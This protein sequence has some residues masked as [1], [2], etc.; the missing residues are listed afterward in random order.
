[1]LAKMAKTIVV[2]VGGPTSSGKTTIAKHLLALIPP[3]IGVILHQDD[4]ALPEESLPFNETLQ[5][6]DWDN[7]IGT[8]DYKRM[9]EV[10]QHAKAFG[11]LPD[12]HSSHDHLN[13]QPER[14]LDTP[15][16]NECK[17]RLADA[18]R[19]HPEIQHI[20]FA[21]GFLLYYDAQVRKQMDIRLFL[22]CDRATLESRRNERG[23]YA[24]AENTVWQDP[25][26]YFEHVIWPGYVQA[27]K[28]MFVNEDIEHGSLVDVKEDQPTDGAPVKNLLLIEG[29]GTH[30]NDVVK[31]SVNEIVRFLDA[32]P[33]A[34]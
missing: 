33:S 2:G 31:S 21:D 25:P 34:S 23:G 16:A 13:L 7:P 6:R 19:K 1:M 32:T 28:N 10:L 20:I 8:I 29:Q 27:H 3:K 24:T 18:L 11:K 5:A 22:R 26:G 12:H 4:F 17:Q 15:F 14:P 30:I 9:K